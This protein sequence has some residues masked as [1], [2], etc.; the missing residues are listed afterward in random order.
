MGLHVKKAMNL[1]RVQSLRHCV[2]ACLRNIH[3]L[4]RRRRILLS[5]EFNLRAANAAETI[6][7]DSSG[8]GR[9]PELLIHKIHDIIK[10]I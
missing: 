7:E 5:I 4:N 10:D 6:V 3:P 8:G 1:I 9:H 2:E